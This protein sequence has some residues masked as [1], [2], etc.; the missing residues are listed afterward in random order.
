MFD[1]FKE[2]ALEL[3]GKDSEVARRKEKEKV[4]EERWNR[5]IFSKNT[6]VVVYVL[7]VLYLV[8][9]GIGIYISIQSGKSTQNLTAGLSVLQCVKYGFLSI[10]DI[11]AMGCL[12]SGKKKAEIAALILIFVFVVIMYSSTMIVPFM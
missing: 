6:K 8:M 3:S 9:G 2:I 1:F 10:T 7:G 4:E 5:F 11:A 12:V